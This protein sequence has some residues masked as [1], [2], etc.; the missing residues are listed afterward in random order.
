MTRDRFDTDAEPVQLTL[1][2][3]PPAPD[4]CGTGDLLELLEPA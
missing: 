1:E 2:G 4:G 3:M